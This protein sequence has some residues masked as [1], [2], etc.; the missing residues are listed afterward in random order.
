MKNIFIAFISLLT[1]TCFSK[2]AQAQTNIA[3]DTIEW[4]ASPYIDS[5]QD[6][7]VYQGNSVFIVYG[8]KKIRWIQFTKSDHLKKIISKNVM[9]K[10]T[11]TEGSWADVNVDGQQIY[12]IKIKDDPGMVRIK[13]SGLGCVVHIEWTDNGNKKS[14]Y[15]FEVVNYR[16]L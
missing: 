10:I 2:Q 7:S 8:V 6:S 5:N 12:Q 13:R 4:T 11:G 16:K 3:T 9:L 15:D 14:V 1:I